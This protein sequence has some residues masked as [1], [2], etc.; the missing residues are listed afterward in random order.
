M[1]H[2]HPG[3]RKVVRGENYVVWILSDLV[4]GSQIAEDNSLRHGKR[5]RRDNGMRNQ[6]WYL[7]RGIGCEW[8]HNA[9]LGLGYF[10]E[11][12][13]CECEAGHT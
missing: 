2:A 7:R 1:S 5:E 8:P 11:A 4:S 10:S 3:P 12:I 9:H 6:E 13:Q